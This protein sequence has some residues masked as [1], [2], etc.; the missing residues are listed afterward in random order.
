MKKLLLLPILF[1]PSLLFSQVLKEF[2]LQEMSEQQIPVFVE[3]PNES[4]LIFYT[5][6]NG[7]TVQSNTGGIVKIESEATKVTVFLKPERQILTLK[8]PGFIE[9]KHLIESISAK[10]TKFFRLNELESSNTIETG[11]YKIQTQPE[12]V[13]LKIEG[14]SDFKKF[15]PFEL[16]DYRAGK[17][18]IFLTKPDYYPLDTLIEIR[19]GMKQNV[20]FELR[21]MYGTL[22]L[23]TDLP[24]KVKVGG[25]ILD[26]GP[27]Q[28]SLRLRDGN[29]ELSVT[30]SRF[31]PYREKVLVESG[32]TKILDLQ[33]IKRSG[34]LQ[35]MHEDGFDVLVNGET[36][37]KKP[38]TQLLEFFEGNYEIAVKRPG[39]RPA[40]FPFSI[41]KGDIINWEPIFKPV[42][43]LMKLNTDPAGALVTIYRKGEEETI[44]FSPFEEAISV[45][46]IEILLK[47][48]GFNDYRFIVNLEEEKPYSK[49]INL[50][51]PLKDE[52]KVINGIRH[53]TLDYN[54]YTYKTVIIGKQEWLAE[55]LR[56][57][58][59][60][61][62]TS[63]LNIETSSNWSTTSNGAYCSYNQD[64]RNA[65][66]YGY[67]YN[68]HAVNSGKLAPMGWRVPSDEDWTILENAVGG[69]GRK[70]KA[71]SGWSILS[72]DEFGFG[73]LPGGN[74]DN[75]FGSFGN[76]GIIGDWWSSTSTNNIFA[77]DRSLSRNNDSVGRFNN[78]LNNG[79]SVRLLR[80]VQ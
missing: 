73:A 57:T 45:G 52:F 77:I 66:K 32:K 17:Y 25:Q 29:Y 37:I 55:N 53:G 9:K 64:Q 6:I 79:F 75:E 22:S 16:L 58:R 2:D 71:K 34:F 23:R 47:K 4:A 80:D 15:T 1:L 5:A 43:V 24:V 14:I 65:E 69:S 35:I 72:N 30:D 78:K 56:T 74:R 10:Q 11:S 63:I 13:L 46:E 51:N 60:N 62:G 68:W 48:E 28:S 12:G 20:L 76:L 18:R 50:A 40:N 19:P 31:D 54:G 38:G 7:F 67:L 49:T 59:Y 42:T 26:A 8:A 3:H 41:K 27:E 61:D 44:G 39:F 21:S 70:L 36:R 33:L